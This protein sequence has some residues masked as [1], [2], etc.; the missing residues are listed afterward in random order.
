MLIFNDLGYVFTLVILQCFLIYVIDSCT[1]I[2]F[3][4]ITLYTVLRLL[5]PN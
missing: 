1:L 2:M 3:L 5:V 4:S